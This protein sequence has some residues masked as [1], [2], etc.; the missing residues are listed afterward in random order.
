MKREKTISSKYFDDQILYKDPETG[1]LHLKI[2]VR[3]RNYSSY[4]SYENM[5]QINYTELQYR[6][7]MNRLEELTNI[8]IINIQ[9]SEE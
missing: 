2:G 6:K 8:N 4:M 5:D 9:G 3:K 7:I 1:D